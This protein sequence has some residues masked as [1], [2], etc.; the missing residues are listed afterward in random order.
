MKG[1]DLSLLLLQTNH[2]S[3]HI[4]IDY[5][6]DGTLPGNKPLLTSADHNLVK[7]IDEC[8]A[9]VENWITQ[10]KRKLLDLF[11]NNKESV[12]RHFSRN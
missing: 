3:S 4:F 8:E 12:V 10:P 2:D 5:L 1:D 11:W 7:A 6:R 9:F